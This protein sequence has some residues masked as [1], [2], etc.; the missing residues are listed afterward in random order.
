MTGAGCHTGEIS[1]ITMA[2]ADDVTILAEDKRILRFLTNIAVDFSCMEWYLLQPI[3]SVLLQILQH[4]GCLVPD[5][6]VVTVKEQP[7]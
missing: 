2:C 7:M 3:K 1:C 6:T 4:A 5:D